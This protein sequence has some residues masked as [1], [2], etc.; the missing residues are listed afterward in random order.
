MRP[1]HGD[2]LASELEKE[3]L[4]QMIDRFLMFY[5]R[6]ADKLQRTSVWV[7][8]LEGGVEYIC[9]VIVNDSLNLCD[10][11][12]KQI[13]Q[14][15]DKYRCEWQET[16]SQDAQLKRFQHFINSDESDDNVQFVSFRNQHR[17][18][19]LEEKAAMIAAG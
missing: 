5:I 17:P 9:E 15:I 8:S 11:M 12:D 6:T 10:A 7:E 13:N 1:R 3:T 4:I 16:L 18:A 2:L 19:T 14:L